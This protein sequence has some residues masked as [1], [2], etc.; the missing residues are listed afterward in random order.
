MTLF[1]DAAHRLRPNV[2]QGGCQ[3]IED[4]VF[5][6]ACVANSNDPVHALGRYEAGRQARARYI[7][8]L[9]WMMSLAEHTQGRLLATLRDSLV[10]AL[11][12]S[13]MLRSMDGV[14]RPPLPESAAS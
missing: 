13:L 6:A 11:P 10:R 8:R 14:L 7:T 9:S 2:G 4:A 12:I 3:A 5:L 1:G